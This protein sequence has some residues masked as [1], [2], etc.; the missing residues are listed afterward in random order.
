MGSPS[1][2]PDI[3]SIR[4]LVARTRRRVR[5][6]QAM[7]GAATAAVLASAAALLVVFGVRTYALSSGA[8]IGLLIACLGIIAAGA[9]IAATRPL[10]EELVARRIDRASNLSDRL[11]TAVSFERVL[12]TGGALA[13]VAPADDPD[14]AALS[15]DETR[16]LMRAAIK[17]AVKFAPRADW[18]GAAPY[19]APRDTRAA[20]VFGFVALLAAGLGLPDRDPRVITADPSRAARGAHVVI[21]GEWLCGPTAAATSTCTAERHRVTLDASMRGAVPGLMAGGV[22]TIPAPIDAELVAWTGASIEVVIPDGA[23]FGET[24]LTVYDGTRRIGS[25]AFEV[26]DPIVEKRKNPDTVVWDPD[27]QNYTKDLLEELRAIAK[28]DQVPELEAFADKVEELIQKAENGELTKEQLLEELKKAEEALMENG[29]PNPEEIKKD[30]QDTGKELE[31]NELTKELGKALEKGDL[32]KAKEEMEKL[33][34]KL[35]K[36]ELDEKQK[37][38]L[39]KQLEKAADEFEKKQEKKDKEQQEKI[40]K[41]EKEVRR[42]EKE[43]DQE[44]DPKKKEEMERRLEKKKREL[45]Q[46][47]KDKDKKDKSEQRRALKRLHKKMKDAAKDLQQKDD[48]NDKDKNEKSASEKMKDAAE[49]TGKVDQDQRKQATQKKVASQMDDLREAMRRAKRRGSKGPK[50]PFGKNGKQSD[51]DRRA[52]GQKGQKGAWKPG[53]GKGKGQPGDQNGGNGQGDPQQTDTWGTGHDPNLEGDPTAKSG[54]TEDD[55]LQGVHGKGPSRRQTIVSAAQKGFAS[56]AYKKVYADYKE[57]VEEVMRSEKV[58]SSYK[59]YIKKYFTK[60]KPHAMD[61]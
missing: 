29:E 40:D 22:V 35:E 48:P 54:N 27:D 57:I 11:S 56:K 18:R 53:Q 41:A 24:T 3:S 38:D 34:E 9:A 50:N 60:I 45:E 20:A 2:T 7:E 19:V 8:G 49:E 31:K 10:D 46:L 59:Y 55:D 47:K 14:A 42:L 26:I 23:P 52:R 58:P 33:A 12:R 37:K 15:D 51:F 61:D 44:K 39:A 32:E 21:T 43:K 30:L 28:R 4:A 17:D 16:D 36:G 6:Q 13:S 1:G 25:V 5:I